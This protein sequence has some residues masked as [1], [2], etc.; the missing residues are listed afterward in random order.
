VTIA[1]SLKVNDG[2][3]LA[4]DSASTL[5]D[6]NTGLVVNVYNSAN[7]IFNLRKGLPIGA[8][9][10]GAGS[11]GSAAISTLA[12]D[13]RRR[14]SGED[15]QHPDWILDP[16]SYT[17]Q[18]VSERLKTFMY[19]ELYVPA[20]ENNPKKPALGFAVVG[21]SSGSMTGEGYEIRIDE[22]GQCDQPKV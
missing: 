1:I 2:I 14:F 9:T 16:S 13:L 17:I 8:V 3:I 22:N 6:N 20:F 11:I 10:W 21:Y 4:S 5:I 7:K 19:D 15:P 18:A 12:K